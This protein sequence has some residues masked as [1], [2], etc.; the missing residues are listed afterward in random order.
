[1]TIKKTQEPFFLIVKKN[2]FNKYKIN[3]KIDSSLMIREE[4]IEIIIN[5][6]KKNYKIISTT[7]MI[8]R[9]LYEIR[10]KHNQKLQNDFLTVGSMGHASQIA[11]GVALK[12]KK[13]IIC[14]D[15]DGSF[16]M[17]MGGIS[18]IG[19]LKLKNF[20]HI[21]INN[22]AHDSVGGQETSSVTSNLSKIALACSYNKVFPNIN[23]K[24]N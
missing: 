17:H 19:S 23:D 10:K 24:K 13:K 22:Y 15:G 4:A 6:F 2:T 5:N 14:L 18:T 21:V 1:M 12:S 20:I 11:L 16:I 7:G 9:E 8:S 3:K